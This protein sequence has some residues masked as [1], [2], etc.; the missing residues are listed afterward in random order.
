MPIGLFLRLLTLSGLLHAYIALRLLPALRLGHIGMAL[1]I[2]SLLLSTLLMPAPLLAM[3]TL[4]RRWSDVLAWLGY[5]CMGLFS[6]V[7]VFTVLRD[8]ALLLIAL[9][10]W[11]GGN[12]AWAAGF[13]GTSA[14]AIPP[15]AALMAVCG[16][17]NARRL[18]RVVEVDVPIAGLPAALAG[19]SIVQ[20]SDLHVGPTI[21]RGYLEAVVRAVNQL[22]P[23]V[24]AVTGDIVDGS[25]QQ[26]R[27]HVAPL[28]DLR[29]RHGVYAVTGNHEYYSGAQEWVAELRRL[30]LRVMMNQ[31]ELVQHQGC[32]LFRAPF[33]PRAAQ[34]CAGRHRRGHRQYR[35]TGTA[36]ASAAV[37]AGSGSGR[38]RPAD[39]GAY[40][41][42]PV[43]ALEFFRA[44]AAAVHCRPAPAAQA[45]GLYQPRHRLLGPATAL[46]RAF[47][48]HPPAPGRRTGLKQVRRRW[49]MAYDAK[50]LRAFVPRHFQGA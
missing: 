48:N 36:G 9:A 44:P 15:L 41:R 19:F 25:V 1:A 37:G 23:D 29:A 16:L 12:T 11:V 20:I 30:G 26:L 47:G 10:S 8:C 5:L 4:H 35:G 28:A 27:P 13:A 18:A 40:P 17:I 32:R 2:A 38:L 43:P 31:G 39:F 33:R 21:K 7:L 22:Q 42:R 45:M 14:Q 6:C 50:A 46:R 3:R 24:V 49:P 34:R